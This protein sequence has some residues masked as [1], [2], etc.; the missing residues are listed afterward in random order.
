MLYD[1]AEVN[2]HIVDL[3]RSRWDKERSDRKRGIYYFSEG[4][5]AKVYIKQSDYQD[6]ASRP[7][8][9]LKFVAIENVP[10]YRSRFGAELVGIDDPYWPEPVAPDSE[11]KYVILDAVLVKIGRMEDYIDFRKSER[12]R[13]KG[14]HNEASDNFNADAK[15]SGVNSWSKTDKLKL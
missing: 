13:G 8:H 11:G 2:S 14:G 7:N 4:P 12:D 5:D 3:N 10:V 1:L 9:I 6:N 15:A